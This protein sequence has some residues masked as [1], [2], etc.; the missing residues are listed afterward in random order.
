MSDEKYIL[1]KYDRDIQGLSHIQR[2]LAAD[3]AALKKSDEAKSRMIDEHRQERQEMLA[4]IGELMRQVETL[5]TRM[6]T[7]ARKIG[8]IEKQGGVT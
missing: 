4:K 6:D 3:M 2:G 7:A 8:Q 1:A 5:T